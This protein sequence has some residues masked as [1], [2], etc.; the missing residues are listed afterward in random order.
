VGKIL[1]GEQVKLVY[2]NLYKV[3][4]VH[5]DGDDLAYLKIFEATTQAGIQAQFVT[6]FQTFQATMAA[7]AAKV[8]AEATARAAKRKRANE[9]TQNAADAEA[10][11]KDLPF[12]TAT[13]PPPPINGTHALAPPETDTA[14]PAPAT[15][16]SAAA[17]S[18]SQASGGQTPQTVTPIKPK[19]LLPAL[20]EEKKRSHA[21]ATDALFQAGLARAKKAKETDGATARAVDEGADQN[22]DEE[23]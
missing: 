8:Q 16:E 18:G 5:L 7:E 20:D 13:S 3:D 9:D 22:S 17:S 19:R 21:A 2:D 4:D 15:G 10:A 1:A 6:H 23:M 12:P 11:N 14:T